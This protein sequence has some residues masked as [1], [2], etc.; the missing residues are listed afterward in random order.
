MRILLRSALILSAILSLAV[1][2][3]AQVKVAVEHNAG[4]AATPSFKFKN[5]PSPA[6]DD[7]ASKAKLTLLDGEVD[8]NSADLDALTD[9]KLPAFEDEPR[10]NFFFAQGT[11]GGRLAMDLARVLEIAQVNSY[12]WHP[13]TRGPQVY[14]LYASDGADP[15]FNAA[16]KGTIDPSTCG[17]KLVATVDT[18]PAQGEPGG[19]YA[20]SITDAGGALGKYRYLLFDVF[21]T[22]VDDD[23]GNSFYSE[24]DVIEKK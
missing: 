17:W 13:N 11:G 20:L 4:T 10:A 21:V 23:F 7:A 16:P 5:V 18:R 8:G 15:K 6:K 1:T 9:G 2:S 14:K 19:Q 3:G 22:E 24:I 12:S